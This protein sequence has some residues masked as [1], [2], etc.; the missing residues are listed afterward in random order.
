MFV[1]NYNMSQ[2]KYSDSTNDENS[3]SDEGSVALNGTLSWIPRITR[4]TNQNFKQV[5]APMAGEMG[6]SENVLSCTQSW[7]L[8]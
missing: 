6:A 3:C 5:I 4:C 8:T 1:I 7:R 2:S